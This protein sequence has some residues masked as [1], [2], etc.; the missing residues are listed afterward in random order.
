MSDRN[1]EKILGAIGS[2][3]FSYKFINLE[4][5]N[6]I[7]ESWEG[8]RTLTTRVTTAPNKPQNV[9]KFEPDLS[10]SLSASVY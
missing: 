7:P 1:T 6:C 2:L 4:I 9:S 5:K 8:R 10:S 3:V